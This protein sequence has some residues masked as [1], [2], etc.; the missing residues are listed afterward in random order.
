MT[1]KKGALHVVSTHIGNVK[2]MTERAIEILT[3]CDQVVCE[4]LKEARRLLHHLGLTKE[5]LPL[6]E[7][8]IAEA[9]QEALDLLNVGKSLALISDAGTPLL[10]DPGRELVSSATQLG[11]FVTAVPGASSILPALVLSGMPTAPFTF[12]GFLP[13]DKDARKSAAARWATRHETLLLLEAP[14]RLRQVLSDLVQAFGGR[15]NAAI[16][17]DLTLPTERVHR[18]SLLTLQSHFE[19]HPFKGEFVIV[20]EGAS[21]KKAPPK[22]DNDRNTRGGEQRPTRR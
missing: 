15:R 11:H 22:R 7:H 17:C 3:E 4:D 5:L 12:I 16:C 6:N 20:I 10:A 9:T 8:T 14:Y 21:L 2:D 18:G 13:R 1:Q 19:A